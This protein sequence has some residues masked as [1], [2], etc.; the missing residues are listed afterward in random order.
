MMCRAT[1]RSFTR[2]MTSDRKMSSF[3]EDG[4]LNARLAAGGGAGGGGTGAEGVEVGSTAVAVVSEALS[5]T[6]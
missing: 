3:R 1:P 5:A 6:G 4:G 2:A